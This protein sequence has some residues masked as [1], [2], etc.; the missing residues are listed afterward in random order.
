MW[1][2]QKFEHSFVETELSYVL[3]SHVCELITR[4]LEVNL[5]HKNIFDEQILWEQQQTKKSP[6]EIII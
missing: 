6:N 1:L 5:R 4:S 2:S 3:R